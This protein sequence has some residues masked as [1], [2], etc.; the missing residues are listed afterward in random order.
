MIR[1]F[2]S[3]KPP[4][5]P[6]FPFFSII[7]LIPLLLIFS[8]FVLVCM[9]KDV[10]KESKNRR[11]F[12]ITLGIIMLIQQIF[13]YSWYMCSGIGLKEAL[14]LYMCRITA[15]ILIYTLF[16][17]TKKLYFIIYFWG[18]FG[19]TVAL[20]MPDTS[21]Y[22]FP[23]IMFVQFFITHGGILTALLFF[24]VVDDYRPEWNDFLKITAFTIIYALIINIINPLVGGNYAYFSAPP[25]SAAFFAALPK[26]LI[27]KL[28]LL[29]I[30]ILLSFILYIPFIIIGKVNRKTLSQI[31]YIEIPFK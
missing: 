22:L 29:G 28:G 26:G 27:Y 8:V 31:S 2:F 20:L 14:P 11:L 24:M 25:K 15:L 12:M 5:N 21:G 16:T 9:K 1:H 30:L 18:L 23:H 13:F 4:E 19:A 10:L 6:A 7:H 17:D 3:I